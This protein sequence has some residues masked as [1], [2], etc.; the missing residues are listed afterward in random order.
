MKSNKQSNYEASTLYLFI[1]LF[2]P[3]GTVPLA[4]C[5]FSVS[6]VR[7]WLFYLEVFATALSRVC[8]MF[9]KVLLNKTL[10]RE[11]VYSNLTEWSCNTI[12]L[13]AVL[14]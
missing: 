14:E 11:A 5:A 6:I 10:V 9:F 8:I 7:V 3:S 13:N 1:F 2:R 12:L 4:I